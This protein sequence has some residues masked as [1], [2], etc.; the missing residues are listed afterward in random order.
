MVLRAA[1]LAAGLLA[2]AGGAAALPA[3]DDPLP[4]QA[5]ALAAPSVW[6]GVERT[7][8]SAAFPVWA[9][10]RAPAL[11]GP[12]RLQWRWGVDLYQ[13]DTDAVRPF[14]GLGLRTG[15]RT[16]LFYEQRWP[17]PAL[18]AASPL[19]EPQDE[20]RL[21][22]EFRTGSKDSMWRDFGTL[23]LQVGLHGRLALRPRRG[24]ATISWHSRF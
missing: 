3:A 12:G 4:L 21:G 19:S 17:R 8:A 20:A 24:G 22:L 7:Q 16:T 6:A 13:G 10:L 1:L 15:L 2:G 23:R 11:A 14:V 5:A 9:Q 18:A